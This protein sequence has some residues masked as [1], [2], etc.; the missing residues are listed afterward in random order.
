M[1]KDKHLIS[2]MDR[3]RQLALDIAFDRLG[4]NL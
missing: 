3:D 1:D 4:L 2:G